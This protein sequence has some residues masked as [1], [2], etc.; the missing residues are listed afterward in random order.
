VSNDSSLTVLSPRARLSFPA[1]FVPAAMPGKKDVKKYKCELLFPKNT[2]LSKLKAA[3]QAAI[4]K[5]WGAKPSRKIKLPFR[6]GDNMENRQPNPAYEGCIF[7]SP[8]A[9]DKPVVAVGVGQATRQ[10]DPH[11]VYSGCYGVAQLYAHAYEGET[12]W[13]VT[14]ILKGFAKTAEGEPLGRAPETAESAFGDVEADADAF[15]EESLV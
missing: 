3:C 7:I 14:F 12:G 9:E 5:K 15:G 11:E 13:G 10:A 8:T 6:D 1:L 4:E 2:D